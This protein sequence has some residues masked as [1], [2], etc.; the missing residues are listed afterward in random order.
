MY[1][2][3]HSVPQ[4]EAKAATEYRKAASYERA[5]AQYNLGIRYAKGQGVPENYAEA[6]RWCSKASHG[7]VKT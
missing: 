3:R 5:K 2:L 6:M 4:D 1:I 7:T